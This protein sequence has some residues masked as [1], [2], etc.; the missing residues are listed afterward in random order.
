MK[1][2]IGDEVYLREDSDWSD[3]SAAN[4][5]DAVGTIDMIYGDEYMYDYGVMWSN[6]IHNRC[7]EDDDLVLSTEQTPTVSNFTQED[8]DE[9]QDRIELLESLLV[10]ANKRIV[11]LECSLGASNRVIQNFSRL[12]YLVLDNIYVADLIDAK[13]GYDVVDKIHTYLLNAVNNK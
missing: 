7:Y 6:G 2:K 10:D 4:P 13:W 11:D 8:Y 12:T 3:G 5:L 1:F 9:M